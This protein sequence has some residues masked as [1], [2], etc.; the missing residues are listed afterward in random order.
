VRL[1]HRLI[2]LTRLRLVRNILALYGVRAVDQL[3]PLMV[4]PYLARTLG[5]ANWG[6][7]AIAQAF[8]IY[9]IVTVEYG[10][11][12]SGTRAGGGA[13]GLGG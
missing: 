13:G 9:G 3:L 5:P 10:F 8:A 12:F 4:L 2:A 7:F 11:N 6:V 1:L